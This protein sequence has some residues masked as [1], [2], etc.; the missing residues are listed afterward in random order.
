MLNL[1]HKLRQKNNEYKTVN[2]QINTDFLDFEF[3][4]K[5]S[6][7]KQS[8]CTEEELNQLNQEATEIL[9]LYKQSGVLLDYDFRVLNKY[10][11]GYLNLANL[12]AVSTWKLTKQQISRSS[13]TESFPKEPNTLTEP[14]SKPD[15]EINTFQTFQDQN[16]KQSS[17][18]N[19]LKFIKTDLDTS[20]IQEPKMSASELVK[21]SSYLR[22]LPPHQDG[23]LFEDFINKLVSYFDVCDVLDD[24]AKIK[25]LKYSVAEKSN[26][27]SILSS[28]SIGAVPNFTS[29]ANECIELID[30]R[31][32][33]TTGEV[34]STTDI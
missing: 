34:L 22:S 29:F 24:A 2:F 30:G 32:K 15:P 23:M 31:I 25:L 1:T 19:S 11:R 13:S 10:K 26:L 28:I 33:P 18:S 12:I 6:R 20:V 21:L 27:Q 17:S 8:D 5:F 16:F 7:N 14:E 3:I 9:R 4:K